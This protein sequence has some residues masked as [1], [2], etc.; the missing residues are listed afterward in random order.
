MYRH[1]FSPSFCNIPS[2][3]YF[4][5]AVSTTVSRQTFA[6]NILAAYQEYDLD[7]IDIDWEYPG[8][9]DPK[10]N[11]FSPDDSAN[12]LIFLQLLRGILPTTARISAA[13]QTTPFVGSDGAPLGDVSGFAKVLDWVLL[14]N[15]DTWGC[16]YLFF[17]H[18]PPPPLF[19]Q[20]NFQHNH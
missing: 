5:P 10:S 13:V 16:P 11:N 7:G 6:L 17:Q 14:M 8:Q 1:P 20:P 15:Y 19:F 2:P 4:S 12:F 18:P 9:Q 3:R